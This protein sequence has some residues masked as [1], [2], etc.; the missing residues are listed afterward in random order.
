MVT[1]DELSRQQQ[2][3]DGCFTYLQDVPTSAITL[4]IPA[5][6]QANSIYCI[7]P[8]KKKAMAVFHTLNSEVNKNYPSTS[9]KKHSNATLYLD[10]DSAS[11]L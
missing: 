6:L 7:V 3:H 2:L 9:L 4:T 10:M 5:L 8:G 1:L 11:E